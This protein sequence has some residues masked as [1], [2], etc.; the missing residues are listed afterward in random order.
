MIKLN[1]RFF[2]KRKIDHYISTNDTEVKI[3]FSSENPSLLGQKVH[4][5]AIEMSPRALRIEVPFPLEIGSVLDIALKINGLNHD[6]HLTGNIRWRVPSMNGNY[7]VGLVLRERSDIKSDFKAWKSN[8]I[9]N[10]E[11]ARAC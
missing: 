4:A 9:Q 8:F 3:L 2:E 7:H 11:Q 1:K 10:F 6:Y 5:T